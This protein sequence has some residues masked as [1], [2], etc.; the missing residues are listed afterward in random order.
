MNQAIQPDDIQ[1]SDFSPFR[2]R[3]CSSSNLLMP[4]FPMWLSRQRE[5]LLKQFGANQDM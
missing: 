4:R 1:T 5:C 2:L 3:P